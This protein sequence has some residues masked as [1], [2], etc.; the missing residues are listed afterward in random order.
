MLFSIVCGDDDD[1]E[2]FVHMSGAEVPSRN[3]YYREHVNIA[4][5][6]QSPPTVVNNGT[7]WVTG[8]TNFADNDDNFAG[9]GYRLGL[10]PVTIV[11]CTHGFVTTY[12]FI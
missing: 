4:G 6:T 8:V 3:D 7:G 11:C 5:F 1:D 12:D 9:L 2:G 10:E